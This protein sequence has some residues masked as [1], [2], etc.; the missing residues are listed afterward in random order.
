MSDGKVK[1]TV[2]DNG[3]LRIEGDIELCDGTGEPYDLAGR[4]AI[5]LCRCAKSNKLPFCD[6]AHGQ[7]GFEQKVTAAALPPPKH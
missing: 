7:C 6:G 4:K 1:I 2:K 3:P 5:S